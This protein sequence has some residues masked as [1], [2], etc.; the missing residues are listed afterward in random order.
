MLP[1]KLVVEHPFDV[2]EVLGLR[3]FSEEVVNAIWFIHD[4]VPKMNQVQQEV[5]ALLAEKNSQAV[6]FKAATLERK[7]E[8]QQRGIEIK[9]QVEKKK[10][11]AEVLKV[12]VREAELV[13]PNIPQPDVP[14]SSD[15]VGEE[16]EWK[17]LMLRRVHRLMVEYESV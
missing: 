16:L 5:E 7:K 3:G 1:R 2:Q 17:R 8:L 9:A 14:L 6:L 12:Q 10:A 4:T 13:L 15:L 11:E